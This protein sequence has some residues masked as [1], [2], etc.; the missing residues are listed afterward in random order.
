[1]SREVLNGA[2]FSEASDVW[3]FGVTL[4]EMYTYG[5]QPFEGC[6]NQDVM[7]MINNGMALD[8]PPYCPPH[9]Y[10]YVLAGSK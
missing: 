8:C 6:N 5:R 9:I 4:W 7:E 1:M 2:P 10:K 3:A